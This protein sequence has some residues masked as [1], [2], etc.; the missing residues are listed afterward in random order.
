MLVS[1]FRLLKI[2]FQSFYRNIW[3]SFATLTVIILSLISVNVLIIL[4]IFT[5]ASIDSV[6]EKIDISVYLKPNITE[7]Q[8]YA[9]KTKIESLDKV[10]KVLYVSADQALINFKKRHLSDDVLMESIDELDNNPLG[11]TFIIKAKNTNDYPSI[12]LKIE[13]KEFTEYS[14]WIADKDFNN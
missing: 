7:D 9:V 6:K 5:N 8:A 3:L 11:I 4:N 1:L 2:A 13:G 12:L 10:E 14:N